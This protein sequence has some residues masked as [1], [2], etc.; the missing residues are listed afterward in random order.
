[1]WADKM[2]LLKITVNKNYKLWGTNED[3]PNYNIVS[4]QLCYWYYERL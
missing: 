3:I 1:M 4:M 2:L